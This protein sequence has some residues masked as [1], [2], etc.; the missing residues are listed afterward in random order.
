MLLPCENNSLKE[1][2]LAR[3]AQRIHKNN[4]L[5]NDENCCLVRIISFELELQAHIEQLKKSL[6][7]VKDFTGQAAFDVIDTDKNKNLNAKEL[8]AFLN[9][10][11]VVS[12]CYY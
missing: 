1:R 4:D 2:T 9:P 3:K 12:H 6:Q 7:A 8:Y 5:H 10:V 11:V